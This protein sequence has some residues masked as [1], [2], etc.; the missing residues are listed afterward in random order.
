MSHAVAYFLIC[1]VTPAGRGELLP[2]WGVAG[3]EYVGKPR[4][5]MLS[6]G[7]VVIHVLFVSY[8]L[9]YSIV[10]DII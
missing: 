10:L 5:Q 4:C 1:Y 6:V 2:L 9:I 7:R 3:S 8:G